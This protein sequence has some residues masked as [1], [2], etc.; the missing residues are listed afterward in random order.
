MDYYES[1]DQDARDSA[2]VK[3]VLRRYGALRNEYVMVQFSQFRRLLNNTRSNCTEENMERLEKQY[4]ALIDRESA[5]FRACEKEYNEVMSKRLKAVKAL[6]KEMDSCRGL[7]GTKLKKNRELFIKKYEAVKKVPQVYIDR[8]PKGYRNTL[9][10][11]K[12]DYEKLIEV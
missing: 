6:I 5:E 12:N 9:N 8:L 1:M 2:P 11:C 4:L 7:F 10:S 3:E